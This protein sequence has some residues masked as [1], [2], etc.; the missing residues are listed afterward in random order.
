MSMR[1]GIFLF[2]NFIFKSYLLV[3]SCLPYLVKACMIMSLHNFL[4]LVALNYVELFILTKLL[5]VVGT[6]DFGHRKRIPVHLQRTE[7][8]RIAPTD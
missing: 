4:L 8:A 1:H 6:N 2:Q 3:L 7:D 5:K